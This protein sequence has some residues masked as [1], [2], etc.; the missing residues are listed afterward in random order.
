MERALIRL[1][2]RFFHSI[3]TYATTG[4]DELARTAGSEGKGR[5]PGASPGAQFST[6][7]RSRNAEPRRH[8]DLGEPAPGRDLATFSVPPSLFTRNIRDFRV[9]VVTKAPIQIETT[10][11]HEHYVAPDDATLGELYRSAGMFVSTA[12][13]EGL[14]LP[15]LE[16]MACGVPVVLTDQR[17]CRDYAIDGENCLKVPIQRPDVVAEAI[18]RLLADRN[19]SR[20]SV[21]G[22]FRAASLY[23]WSI[24][25][26]DFNNP[27]SGQ[28]IRC[29]HFPIPVR[30]VTR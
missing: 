22:G 14:G 12:W 2:P 9:C 27:S 11:P 16:A 17:G 24:A 20:P 13:Y 6:S 23:Q 26:K 7:H 30:R 18:S 5:S 8:V 1:L 29:R 28:M 3:V 4:A 21:T 25:V 19:L 10:V 15:P